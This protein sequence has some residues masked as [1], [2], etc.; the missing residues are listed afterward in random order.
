M[1]VRQGDIFWVNFGVP[2]GAS[3]GYMRPAIV[4]QNNVFNESNIGTVIVC[5]LTT[6]LQRKDAPGNVLL[7]PGEGNLSEQSVVN[8]S[9]IF[10]VDKGDLQRKIGVL[11]HERVW[12]IIRGLKLLL[13]PRSV[14]E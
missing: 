1:R 5:V 12:E 7:T 14:P 3:P 13:E 4:V 11:D 2:R 8:V 10:T 9:Q 6:N